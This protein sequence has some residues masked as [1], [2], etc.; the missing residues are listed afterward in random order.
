VCVCVC[1]CVC[2]RASSSLDRSASSSVRRPTERPPQAAAAPS[3]ALGQVE[4]RQ[5]QASSRAE[6]ELQEEN[7]KLKLK[8][9]KR[10]LF[11]RNPPLALLPIYSLR[12]AR[13]AGQVRVRATSDSGWSR[14]RLASLCCGWAGRDGRV[15]GGRRR[16]RRPQRPCVNFSPR[17]QVRHRARAQTAV[18][19]AG[20]SHISADQTAS[21]L[22]STPNPPKTSRQDRATGEC[23]PAT[24]CWRRRCR[25]PQVV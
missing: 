6:L 11:N 17:L 18:S 21:P 15:R 5:T 13:K 1:V 22:L 16:S 23:E 4:G 14:A 2:A 20:S 24:N 3:A 9:K 7:W 10:L 8:A 12:G 19:P 25:Q